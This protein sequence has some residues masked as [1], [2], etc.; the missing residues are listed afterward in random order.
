MSLGC[1][2]SSEILAEFPKSMYGIF[3]STTDPESTLQANYIADN[4]AG[5]SIAIEQ[6]AQ[7]NSVYQLSKEYKINPYGDRLR[8][9]GGLEAIFGLGSEQILLDRVEF[10]AYD[11][12][13]VGSTAEDADGNLFQT[14][15]TINAIKASAATN[16]KV[17]AQAGFHNGMIGQWQPN[18]FRPKM[19]IGQH[20]L[21]GDGSAG[22]GGVTYTSEQQFGCPFPHCET[23]HRR[24]SDIITD[25]NDLRIW[26]KCT[27]YIG[28]NDTPETGKLQRYPVM[29]IVYFRMKSR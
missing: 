6:A 12:I 13:L 26:A 24:W 17:Y 8:Y 28:N 7:T 19:E 1:S 4:I 21:L 20:Q 11:G 2:L 3:M 22:V 27:Q 9:C 23:F 29:A 14:A 18:G 16:A 15:A 10:F 25:Y 5:A